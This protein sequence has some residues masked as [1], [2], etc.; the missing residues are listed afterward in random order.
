MLAG[1]F[2]RP[3][4][5]VVERHVGRRPADPDGA[6]RQDGTAPVTIPPARMVNMNRLGR[7]LLE[8]DPR[9]EVLFVQGANPAVTAPDQ[10]RVLAGLARED[11]F[12]VVHDQV[13]T[14]TARFADIV[15]PATTHFEADDVADSYGSFTVTPMPA[16]ID[17]VGGSRTNDEVAAGTGRTA[18]P[19]RLR[20][21]RWCPGRTASR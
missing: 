2:G 1:Q 14:D 21:G 9:V 10:R 11:L 13:L 12:T 15:L 5:G 20:P 19:G 7:D 18:G 16:V 8:A 6:L 3:G 17:R 4:A